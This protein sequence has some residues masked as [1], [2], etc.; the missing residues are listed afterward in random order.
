MFYAPNNLSRP[1]RLSDETRKFAYES[2][3][4]KYGLDTLK[5]RAIA[6][7]NI[8]GFAS[9]SPIEKYDVSIK[10]IASEAP[11]RI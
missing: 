11:I 4:R 5:V 3:N 8:E 9:L 10:K 2:L 1:V 7:D 6:L